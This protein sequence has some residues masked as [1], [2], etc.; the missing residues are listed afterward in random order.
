MEAGVMVIDRIS[1]IAVSNG[2]LR[3]ECVAVNAT[4]QEKPAGMV[5]I[6]V[7]V[8][9]A[10][11]QSLVGGLQELDKKLREAAAASDTST[12]PTGTIPTR[13]LS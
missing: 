4:G 1:N 6:P 2:I 3:I 10:V 11:V 8:A 5:L 12:V 9:G 13:K 7:N